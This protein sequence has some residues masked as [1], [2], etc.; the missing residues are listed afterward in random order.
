[1]YRDVSY[2]RMRRSEIRW[3]L[4][5][6]LIS[7]TLLFSLAEVLWAA[8][9][10]GSQ[11]PEL[12]KRIAV[13]DFDVKA[14][15]AP[16]DL[17]SSMAEML[18][19]ALHSTGRFIVLE[20]KAIEDILKEQGIGMS[21]AIRAGTE[22]RVGEML[23]AQVLIKGTITEFDEIVEG[24]AGIGNIKL[25]KIKGHVVID[26]RM[27][28]ANTGVILDSRRSEATVS[29]LAV[30]LS[31]QGGK[32]DL[33]QKTPLVTAI[34]QAIDEAVKFIVGKMESVPWQ[35]R[36]VESEAGRVYVNAGRELGLPLG[37]YLEVY[38]RGKELVDPDTG[39]SLGFQITKIGLIQVEQVEDKFSICKLIAGSPGSK[40]D[41]VKIIPPEK[42]TEVREELSKAPSETAVKPS[43]GE[44]IPSMTVVVVIPERHIQR[45]IPDPAGETEIIRKLVESGFNVVDQKKVEEIRYNELVFTALKDARAAISIG[46]DFGADVI[47]IGEAFSEFA[48]RVSNMISCRARIEARIIDINTGRILAADGREA[49]A[50]DISEDIAAKKAL[51]QAGSNLAD[52]FIERLKNIGQTPEGPTTRRIELL[53]TGIESYGQLRDFENALKGLSGVINVQRRS[54]SE[55]TA[56]FDVTAS[57]DPMELADKLYDCKF[58]SFRIEISSFTQSKLE[59]MVL[60][61]T[62]NTP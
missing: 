6:I 33:T 17:G 43:R 9:P 42:V 22:A 28:D 31:S 60:P 1:M 2:L 53:L 12:K 27:F 45:H 7:L 4:I 36:V 49:S 3:V 57:I 19:T 38:K 30:S 44:L 46:R 14:P 51:R 52:Y 61:A 16:R 11:Y 54:Y 48:G 23:G 10:G 15:K 26:I 56:R 20:R 21:G 5:S 32:I 58:S 59:V 24:E 40:G 25:K 55:N 37:C 13:L 35:G 8:T 18:I 47:I 34:R 62:S 41:I 50:I 39:I 29:D